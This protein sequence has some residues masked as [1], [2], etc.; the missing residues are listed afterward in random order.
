[1]QPIHR[2]SVAL[3]HPLKYGPKLGSVYMAEVSAQ[4]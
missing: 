4:R 1:L 3:L 2:N